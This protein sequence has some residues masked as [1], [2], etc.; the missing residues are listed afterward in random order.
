MTALLNCVEILSY[1]QGK[2]I[3]ISLQERKISASDGALDVFNNQSGTPGGPS[4][5]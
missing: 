3:H 2:Q 4:A 1:D 5:M